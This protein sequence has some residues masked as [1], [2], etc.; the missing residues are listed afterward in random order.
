MVEIPDTLCCLFSAEIE[1]RGN[2]FMIELP[3]EG[4]DHGD[5]SPGGTARLRSN[6]QSEAG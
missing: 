5:I 2:S 6:H 4:I 3:K 1:Q